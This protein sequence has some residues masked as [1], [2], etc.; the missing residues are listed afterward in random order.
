M[1]FTFWSPYNPNA[2]TQ[3]PNILPLNT[4][5]AYLQK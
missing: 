5:V 3:T 4:D 1:K 2:L